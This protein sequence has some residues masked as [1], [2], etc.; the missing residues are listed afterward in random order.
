MLKKEK[1]VS[2]WT[3]VGH[4]PAIRGR[5]YIDDCSYSFDVGVTHEFVVRG[6]VWLKD[7]PQD[8]KCMY[9][10]KFHGTKGVL[11]LDWEDYSRPDL[12]GFG[13][14]RNSKWLAYVSALCQG[15]HKLPPHRHFILSGYD[16]ILEILCDSFTLSYEFKQK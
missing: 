7:G 3:E 14:F 16:E 8:E 6:E 2:V 9:E 5:S 10:F 12:V 15:E 4:F 13:E 1:L 11:F